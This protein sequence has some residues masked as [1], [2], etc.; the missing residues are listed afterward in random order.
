MAQGWQMRIGFDARILGARQL[1]GIGC[2]TRNLIRAIGA[3][4]DGHRLTL[5]FPRGA[6]GQELGGGRMREIRSHVPADIREDRFYRCW[7]DWYL[8]FQACCRR[9]DLFHGP[10]YL[11]PRTRRART[12]VTVHDLT[13]VKYPHWAPHCAPAFAARARSAIERA[14]RV[15]AISETTR[16]DI[17]SFFAV[18]PARVR[19]IYYGIDAVFR[20]IDDAAR[21]EKF[22]G[23]YN[24][25]RRF[26]LSVLSINPRKNIPGLLK[27]FARVVGNGNV[28]HSLVIAAKSYGSNDVSSEAERLG[29]GGR[30]VLLDYVPQEELPLLYNCADMFVFPTFYEGFGL[31]PVEAMA[32]GRAVIASN[33]GSLPEVLGD[34]A[35]YCDPH[36]ADALADAIQGLCASEAERARLAARGI[37]QASLYSW[38]RCAAET[39][40]LYE[41]LR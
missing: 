1:T 31:P 16:D 20:P 35:L 8:P 28:P 39:L 25:P 10:S 2:Y 13:H 24:L 29:L 11:I 32:C 34:A 12:V 7:Y 38:E 9:I 30:F 18:D 15:I 6:G 26:V 17:L 23:R 21:L 33:A 37:G 19:V 36:D 27:A 3:I 4:A 41:D 40:A 14:D 22:R 5:F